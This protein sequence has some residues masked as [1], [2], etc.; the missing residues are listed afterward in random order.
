MIFVG[1]SNGSRHSWRQQILCF[2]KIDVYEIISH[3]TETSSC[4]RFHGAEKSG[5][6]VLLRVH[7]VGV[8]CEL[9]APFEKH[10][11]SVNRPP[12]VRKVHVFLCKVDF[13]WNSWF[14]STV[15]VYDQVPAHC[16]WYSRHNVRRRIIDCFL[17]FKIDLYEIV[18]DLTETSSHHTRHGDEKSGSTVLFILHFIG[19]DYELSA[20]FE[21]HANVQRQL[22]EKVPFSL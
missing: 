10:G 16:I 4:S 2:F 6:T 12:T 22:L 17:F 19:V 8:D 15:I 5:S 11:I 3:L 7:S 13:S 9:S 20:L 14:F 21:K 1:S 18:I